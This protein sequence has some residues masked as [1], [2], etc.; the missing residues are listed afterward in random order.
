MMTQNKWFNKTFLKKISLGVVLGGA[1]GFAY[2]YFIGCKSGTCA[3]TSS[4]VNST[5]YGVLLG[6]LWTFPTKKK[7][8]V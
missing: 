1:V 6:V 4:P 8:R 5:M 3:I 7:G 2:Y